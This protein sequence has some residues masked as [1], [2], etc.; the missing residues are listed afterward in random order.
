MY[1]GAITLG[2]TVQLA[3]VDQSRDALDAEHRA[4]QVG[5]LSERAGHDTHRGVGQ[6]AARGVQ[7]LG[8]EHGGP[9]RLLGTEAARDVEHEGA[10]HAH[11]VHTAEQ[12]DDEDPVGGLAQD[13]HQTGTVSR[14]HAL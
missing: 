10:A 13:L 6:D 11:A 1:G 5:R 8:P 4:R 3:Y 14:I 9:A 12:A 2:D 7:A